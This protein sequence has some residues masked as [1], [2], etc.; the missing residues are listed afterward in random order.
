MVEQ[1]LSTLRIQKVSLIRDIV[2]DAM[3]PEIDYANVKS[4]T[5]AVMAKDIALQR[6]AVQDWP[7]VTLWVDKACIPQ[8]NA[9]LKQEILEEKIDSCYY[10]REAFETLVRAT[11]VALMA[12]SMAFRAGRSK[13][14]FTRFFMPWVNLAAE[15]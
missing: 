4:A 15:L 10:S 14:V 1:T 8:D 6:G 5:V 13:N 3:G 9:V 12:R 11:A 7:D 2:Q